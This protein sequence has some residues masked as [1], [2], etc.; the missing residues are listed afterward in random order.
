MFEN[1]ENVDQNITDL[2]KYAESYESNN[3]IDLHGF[4]RFLF[5][6]T[7]NQNDTEKNVT[8]GTGNFVKIMTVHASKGLEFP[9]VFV[10]DLF[11]TGN[12]D[13]GQ[14]RLH[15]TTGLGM[16]LINREKY[17]NYETLGFT[18]VKLANEKDEAAE[19]LRLLY[20][21]LTRARNKI[22]L[23]FP[24]PSRSGFTA[25]LK[26]NCTTVNPAKLLHPYEIFPQTVLVI[27]LYIRYLDTMNYLYGTSLIWLYPCCKVI[28]SSFR[29][30]SGL[31]ESTDINNEPEQD[32]IIDEEQFHELKKRAD[33]IYPYL[34]QNS[35]MAKRSASFS[36]KALTQHT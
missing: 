22:V 27:C 28:Q 21:A 33:Y 5:Y 26:S 29:H 13:R 7:K 3:T 4:L 2:L 10:G 30:H 14:L 23:C 11:S 35:F 24:D 9:V 15:K 36:N 6:V 17:Q 1:A 20:V 18:A 32:A 25:S 12:R 19:K 16:K 31:F 34:V 8:S